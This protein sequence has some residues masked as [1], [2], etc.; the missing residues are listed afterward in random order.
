MINTMM[1]NL[2]PLCALLMIKTALAQTLI[3]A[4]NSENHAT[5]LVAATYKTPATLP[6]GEGPHEIAVSK[7]GRYASSQSQAREKSPAIASRFLISSNA[8][9]KRIS[10]SANTRCRTISKRAATALF[11]G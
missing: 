4:S 6:T 2:L 7:D 3:V 5:L 8:Q 9:S 11:C 1:M 10:I